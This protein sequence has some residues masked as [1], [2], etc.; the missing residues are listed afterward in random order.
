MWKIAVTTSSFAE[1]DPTPLKLLRDA[2]SELILNPYGRSLTEAEARDVLRGCDGVLAGTEPLGAGVLTALPE[3]KVISRC[4]SGLDN[5]DLALAD[6]LGIK[7]FNT[8]DAPAQAVAELT[9]ALA[10][11][12]ARRISSHDQS[13]RAGI[14][15]KKLGRLLAGQKVGVIGYGRI[16]QRVANLFLALGC[17]VAVCDPAPAQSDKE[18]PDLPNLHLTELLAWSDGLTLHC[19]PS[20]DGPL[21]GRAEL[22]KL[23]LGAWLINTARG[24]LIDET[25]LAEAL[26]EGRLSGAALDVFAREPYQG[27]LTG[28]DNIVLTPHIGAYARETRA[29]MEREAAANLLRGLE[30]LGKREKP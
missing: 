22:A 18:I 23:K 29:E 27:P 7:V 26:A 4:G 17:E 14:W 25:A 12:L 28:L 30:S 13:M 21:L 3:L 19:P 5:V 9:L 6:R 11:D 10:L 2:S 1:F 24:N 15:K 20:G 16:G 8:P